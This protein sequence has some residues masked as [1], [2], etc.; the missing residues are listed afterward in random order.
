[1]NLG[2]FALA[3]RG[4]WNSSGPFP[5]PFTCFSRPSHRL[6]E[7][8]VVIDYQRGL[9]HLL[10]TTDAPI[11]LLGHSL[12]A[13]AA[14]QLLHRVSLTDPKGDVRYKRIRG[15]IL[16]NPLP[17][18]RKMVKV[19]YPSPYVPYHYLG[20]FVRD[21][22]DTI[23]AF[24]SSHHSK[25]S[26]FSTIPLLVLQSERDE[27]VPPSLTRRVYEAAIG[28]PMGLKNDHLIG[29]NVIQRYRSIPRALHD[30][31]YTKPRYRLE[32]FQFIRDTISSHG[33]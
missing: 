5:F 17:S 31:A 7:A 33:N 25:N 18:I 29:K 12:G 9:N 26:I 30:D 20:P 14:V 21:K 23:K 2:I 11:W 10:E 3:P 15:M 6:T 13:A 1:M 27:L 28:K 22:W 19:L 8:G 32:I 24:E 4:Y 16:E